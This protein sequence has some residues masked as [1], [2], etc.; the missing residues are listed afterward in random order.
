MKN[1]VR[2][3]GLPRFVGSSRNPENEVDV[4]VSELERRPEVLETCRKLIGATY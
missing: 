2:I 4:V 3:L 1:V